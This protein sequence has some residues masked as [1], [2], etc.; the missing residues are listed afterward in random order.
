VSKRPNTTA[1]GQIV[2]QGKASP[3][4]ADK[5]DLRSLV[6]Q[7]GMMGEIKRAL[8]RHLTPDRMA[9]IVATAV[10]T[11]PHL[12]ECTEI[13]FMGCVLQASQLGLEPNTPLG[14]C[15]LIPRRNRKRGGIFECTFL[16]GYQGMLEL[17]TR[18]GRV[19]G[20]SAQ[21]V[22]DGDLFEH[23]EGLDPKLRHRPSEE[24]ER[25]SR[26]VTHV[27]AIARLR[28]ADPVFQV[29]SRAQINARRKRSASA[30]D[31]PWVTDFDAM[32]RKTA[33][34][35][36]WPWMPKSSEMGVVEALEQA[37]D[38]GIS[39]VEVLDPSVIEA[40]ERQGLTEAEPVADEAEPD[41]DPVEAVAARV[42]EL[43]AKLREVDPEAVDNALTGAPHE[44]AALS[45]L[46]GLEAN[47][48][49]HRMGKAT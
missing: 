4:R 36:L 22:Y 34:R 21:V 32:A 44:A 38:R 10:R 19:S 37:G 27:Y 24:A 13:S 43:A 5:R 8:P 29:L 28:E 17:A 48:E 31:G 12:G 33:V 18:S 7:P 11:T 15:Y 6:L 3:H 14:Q 26:P 40:L 9:R 1:S 16:M 47:L 35:A 23:E 2:P 20:I 45:A 42:Q 49:K 39:Q 30:N 46:Q 41:P 25:E